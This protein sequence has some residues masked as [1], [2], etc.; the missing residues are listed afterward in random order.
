MTWSLGLTTTGDLAL[1][2]KGLAKVTNEQ[3]LIQ[4]LRNELLTKSGDDP[5][6]PTYGTSIEND[7]IAKT[8]TSAATHST[9][10][11]VYSSDEAS[12]LIEGLIAEVIQ[13]HQQRQLG[14]AKIDKITYGAAT[15][16]PAEVVI[17]FNVNHVLQNNDELYVKIDVTTAKNNTSA[18]PIELTL[19]A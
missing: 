16:T 5:L 9:R 6:Y 2:S 4:D 17:N 15:L 11:S 8:I 7:L 19:S 12:V 1:G 10:A 14:R 13:R 18:Y 3:K